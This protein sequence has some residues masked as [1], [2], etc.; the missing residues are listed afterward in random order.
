VT[1]TTLLALAVLAWPALN[2][3]QSATEKTTAAADPAAP[4]PALHY[5]S[6][7]VYSPRGV[8]QGADD[9]AAANARVGQFARGHAD[10]LKAE[11]AQGMGQP[12]KSD[13]PAPGAQP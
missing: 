9:W 3:A 5:Q 6:A 8:A 4:V 13:A 7:L 12:A 1:K 2:L 10:I 11:Q